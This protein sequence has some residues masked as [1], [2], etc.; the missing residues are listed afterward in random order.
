MF[1]VVLRAMFKH[2]STAYIQV[3]GL[4]PHA[5]LELQV[6]SQDSEKFSDTKG[7]HNTYY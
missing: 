5:S 4:L 7:P 6:L 2:L 1:I 3:S